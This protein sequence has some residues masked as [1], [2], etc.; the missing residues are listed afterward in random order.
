MKQTATPFFSIIIPTLNEEEYLPAL[1]TSLTHQRFHRFE[2]IV[3]DGKSKDRTI[4]KAKRFASKMPQFTI[5]TSPAQNVST[6]RNMGAAS[7]RGK[8]LVFLDA[9]VTVPPDYLSRVYRSV[10]GKRVKLLTTWHKSDTDEPMDEF[11][12]SL[13][14]IMMEVAKLVDKPFSGG[15]NTI[16][17]KDIFTKLGGYH[18]R[19]KFAED[20]DLILRASEA[21][22][23]LA[24][25]RDV[26]ITFCMRRFRHY[27]YFKAIRTYAST[28][29]HAL[30]NKGIIEEMFDY[31]MGGQVYK[32][33]TRSSKS[34][35]R[36]KFT[37]KN[38]KF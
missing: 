35:V 16:I 34:E 25:V 7:A 15:W 3:V 28:S 27:G 29:L 22:H 38:L 6:Q 26:K 9:D 33:K 4:A 37:L 13:G 18:E 5:L 8:F 23:E 30:V 17:R 19:F 2:V 21:G 32:K 20:H 11:L 36:K 31:P 14:N 12:N 24:I 10:A 1:L